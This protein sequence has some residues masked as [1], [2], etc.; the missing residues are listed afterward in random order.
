MLAEQIQTNRGSEYHTY[1]NITLC[2]EMDNPKLRSWALNA[3]CYLTYVSNNMLLKTETDNGLH[4]LLDI[5]I[6]LMSD[7]ARRPFATDS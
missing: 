6:Q 4:G 7:D 1:K 3:L 5:L 2:L